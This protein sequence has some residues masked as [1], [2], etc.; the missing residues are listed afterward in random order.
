M[1]F[2][3]IGRDKLCGIVTVSISVN[4]RKHYAVLVV[5]DGNRFINADVT[6]DDLHE[7]I[8]TE[9]SLEGLFPGIMELV[10]AA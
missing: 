8:F 9:E 7:I 10:R 6:T 3:L 1:A 2:K 4:L 5:M